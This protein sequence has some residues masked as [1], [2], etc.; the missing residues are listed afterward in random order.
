MVAALLAVIGVIVGLLNITAAEVKDFLIASVALIVAAGSFSLI[1]FLGTML[2]NILKYIIAMVAP[3]AVI[4]ALIQIWK[5][6][7][8]K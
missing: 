8:S 4:V 5:L 3:A 2:I 1:P 7:K 6:A